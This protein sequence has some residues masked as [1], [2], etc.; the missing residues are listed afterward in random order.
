MH[1][2]SRTAETPRARDALDGK[3]EERQQQ[4]AIATMGISADCGN[5]DFGGLRLKNKHRR[6]GTLGKTSLNVARYDEG[7]KGNKI[8]PI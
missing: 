3:N 6:L 2:R 5:E 7:V 8:E 4:D 1:H